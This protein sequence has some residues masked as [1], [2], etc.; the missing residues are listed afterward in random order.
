MIGRGPDESEQLSYV[1]SQ[2]V[3]AKRGHRA[4]SPVSIANE[5]MA[6]LDPNA[7]RRRKAVPLIYVAAHLHLRQLARAMLARNFDPADKKKQGRDARAIK[8]LFTLQSRYPQAHTADLDDPV[9]VRRED[10]TEDDVNYNEARL[11]AEGRAK[12]AHADALV[13]WWRSEHPAP[14]QP[15]LEPV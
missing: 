11:R 5:C 15:E 8:D 10:M 12:I 4:V 13:A 7:R 9:Y 14:A 3:D 2:V 1:V 6:A